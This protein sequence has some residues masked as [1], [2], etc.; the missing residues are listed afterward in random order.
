MKTDLSV[1]VGVKLVAKNSARIPGDAFMHMSV[2][3]TFNSI[4][5]YNKNH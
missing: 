2:R 4:K 3:V 5:Q 1:I